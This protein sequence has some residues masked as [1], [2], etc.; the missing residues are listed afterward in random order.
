MELIAENKILIKN[1]KGNLI[2]FTGIDGAGKTTLARSLVNELNSRGI[3]YHYVYGRINPFI[4][5]VL[6]II[7]RKVFL[8]NKNI[9]KDY[10][11]YTTSKRAIITTHRLLFDLY[12]RIF[13]FDYYLQ[14][15]FKIIIPSILGMRMVLDRYVYDTIITDVYRDM[16]LPFEEI[17]KMILKILKFSPKPQI[18]FLI[19]V[20]EKI[21]FKRKKDTPSVEYLK[22]LRWIYLKMA[23]KHGMYIL[24]GTNRLED[25]KKEVLNIVE[26]SEEILN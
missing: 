14:L 6:I 7:G 1:M 22:E 2:C 18:V 9:F 15:F 8:K 25:L 19:D 23:K 13:I 17:D 20:P 11:C 3:R 26:E 24:D 12:L 10:K 16:D 21:A 4:S 5:K